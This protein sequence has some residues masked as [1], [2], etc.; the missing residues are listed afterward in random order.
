MMNIF[1]TNL[2]K[3]TTAVCQEFSCQKQAIT[4]IRKIGVNTQFPSIT[5]SLNHLR[6]LGQIIV[7]LILYISLVHK[8][9]EIR[10]VFDT[11]GWVNID[12]LH[13]SSHTF[14]LQK[15]VHNDQT[16]TSNHAVCPVD[17]MLVELN[18]FSAATHTLSGSLSLKHRLLTFYLAFQCV[19]IFLHDP[20]NNAMGLDGLM[21]MYRGSRDIKTHTL[22]LTCPLQGRIQMRIKLIG[23]DLFLCLIMLR[24]SNRRIVCTLFI[25]VGISF[26]VS[27]FYSFSI[28]QLF[29]WTSH[30]FVLLFLG[31][32]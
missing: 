7:L 9:L 5:E 30:L 15:G 31:W 23:L 16:V 18:T 8:W 2:H 1:I 26:H 12:H 19:G 17:T 10:T 3:Y 27:H 13:L 22:S 24:H 29:L 32:E 21:N 6:L 14:L 25:I 11:I 28:C 4:E 20:R